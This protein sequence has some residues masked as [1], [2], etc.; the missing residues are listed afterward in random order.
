MFL[1][2][3]AKIFHATWCLIIIFTGCSVWRGNE[4]SSVTFASEPKN[5]YP[6][7]VVEPAVFQADLVIRSG[8]VER[9]MLLA[10]DGNLRRIDFDVSTENHHAVLI[11]DKE[12]LLFFKRKTFEEHALSANAATFYEPLTTHLLSTREY[13]EF[14]EVGREGSK[15]QFRARFN[16]SANSEVLILFDEAIGL[17]IR[18]EFYAIE[19]DERKL[20]YTVEL[21]NFSKEISPDV[22]DVPRDFRPER[23]N[24]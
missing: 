24:K 17:P 8:E 2:T 1:S 12:Y 7:S 6:F 13:A 22:F 20:Q 3:P 14:D 21:S 5:E 9:H 18:Q 15:I 10:R 16:E 19:S 11:T 23:R 4:N